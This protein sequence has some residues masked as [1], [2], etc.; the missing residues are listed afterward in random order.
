ME[1]IMRAIR[2]T[3]VMVL[4]FSENANNSEEIKREIVLAGNAK[5]TVI[6]VRVEDVVPGDAFAYQFATRQWIDLFDDW[7]S[8]IERLAE[9]IIHTVPAETAG[10]TTSKVEAKAELNSTADTHATDADRRREKAKAKQLAEEEARQREEERKRRETHVPTWQAIV[11][12][13]KPVDTLKKARAM[14]VTGAV[15]FAIITAICLLESM[16]YKSFTWDQL[17]V[18]TGFFYYFFPDSARSLN[19]EHYKWASLGLALLFGSCAVLVYL[20]RSR[21][22][23]CIGLGLLLPSFFFELQILMAGSGTAIMP[24][25][26][27]LAAIL[28]AFVGVRGTFAIS[29]L[30]SDRQATP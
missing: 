27:L 3:K 12:P 23:A 1:A 30:K 11:L 9:W 5:L 14:G 19:F 21:A 13:W 16:L 24:N 7:D 25:V 8:Q 15:C 18:T 28:A 2:T 22:A 26:L 6:P 10:A 29:R 4:V 20:R 17:P